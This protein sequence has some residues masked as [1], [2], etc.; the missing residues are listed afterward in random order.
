MQRWRLAPRIPRENVGHDE[1]DVLTLWQQADC[2][3]F[4][5]KMATAKFDEANTP[6]GEK[7]ATVQRY[8]DDPIF[9]SI[10]F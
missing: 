5:V 2:D 3:R 4:A 6:M 8:D 10:S 1:K 9:V 7:N